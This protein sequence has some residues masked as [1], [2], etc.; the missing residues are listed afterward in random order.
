MDISR[1][2]RVAAFVCHGNDPDCGNIATRE[3]IPLTMVLRKVRVG[4]R[5]RLLEER[6]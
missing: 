5:L 6:L 4:T 2:Q 3:M 1:R